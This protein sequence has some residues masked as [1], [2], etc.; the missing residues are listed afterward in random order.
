MLK[1]P[2]S[3]YFQICLFSMNSEIHGILTI[4]T[5]KTARLG[6]LEYTVK[7]RVFIIQNMYATKRVNK[8]YK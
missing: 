8:L 2:P 7:H 1:I 3:Q 6:T 4:L 5:D